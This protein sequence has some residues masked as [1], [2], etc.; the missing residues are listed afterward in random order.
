MQTYSAIDSKRAVIQSAYHTQGD[1]VVES[2][3]MLCSNNVDVPVGKIVYTGMLNERGGY[4]TD[5]T[6]T[7]T[8]PNK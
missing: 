2:M 8:A 7:R 4:E 3:Q 6:V 1:G 5:C